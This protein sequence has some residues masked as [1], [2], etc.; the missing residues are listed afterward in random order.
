VPTGPYGRPERVVLRP[1]TG[2]WTVAAGAR[3][4]D[5]ACKGPSCSSL[6]HF[7]DVVVEEP[8]VAVTAVTTEARGHE[9]EDGQGSYYD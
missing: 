6:P 8:V 4:R 9:V 2:G 3:A 1:A 7:E 5:R